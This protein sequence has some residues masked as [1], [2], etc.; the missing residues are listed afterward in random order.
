[1]TG[2]GDTMGKHTLP[3]LCGS[4]REKIKTSPLWS[5]RS[6]ETKQHL[7]GLI[8]PECGQASAWAYQEQ[9]FAISCNR[10]NT[11]GARVRTL[12]LF[13]ELLTDIEQ[14]F[15]PT[16][17]DPQRP[18]REYLHSRGLTARSLTGLR[19]EYWRDIRKSGSGGVMFHVG[20][21]AEK[22]VWNGRLFNPPAGEGKTHNKGATAGKFW[23]HPGKEYDPAEPIYATEGIVD[24][25]SLIEM[26]KQAIALLSAG[27]DPKGVDLGPMAASL[28]LAF[29]ADSA[30]A[31][32]LKKWKAAHP[33][34]RAIT[35]SGGD[36]NDLLRRHG[37]QAAH[38]FD[39][40]Q[41]EFEARAS[42]LLAP[43][44]MEY[45]SVFKGF[46]GY[47]PGLFVFDRCYHYAFTTKKSETGLSVYRV[48]NFTVEVDH[49]RLD[50]TLDDEPVYR[51]HLKVKPREGPAVQCSV[52]G[53]DLSNPGSIRSTLLTRARVMWEGEARPSTALATLIAEYKA[54]VVRQCHILG[55]D[56]KSD[57]MVF[58]D[59]LLDRNGRVIFPD[60]QGFYRSSSR[61]YIRPPKIPSLRPKSGGPSL[62]HIYRL[63]NTAWPDNGALC[64]AY[65]IASWFVNIIKPELGFFPFLSLHGDTQTGKTRLVRVL[66]ALQCVDEEGLPMTKLNTGKGEIRKLAQRSG[67]FKALLEGNKEEKLRFDLESLLT[68]YN[69]GN[70]LQVRATK[71][72]D[73]QTHDTEFLSTLVFVQNQEPFRGKAQMERVVSTA[74]F[75]TGNITSSTT[76]AFNELIRIPPR[77]LAHSYIDIMK[78]RRTIEDR[79]QAYYTSARGEVFGV[80]EDN[81]LAENHG[82]VLAFHRILMDLSGAENDLTPFV[83]ALARKKHERCAHRPATLADNF[84]EAV[85]E[86]S[87]ESR[88]KFCELKEGKLYLKL[89]LALKT[90]DGHGFKFMTNQI[91]EELKAHPAFIANRVIYRGYFGE[92]TSSVAR[93]WVFDA[94][95]VI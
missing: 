61:E 91:M 42:L 79:W 48:S 73:I 18:A 49:Y 8:C 65:T 15:A 7:T 21:L 23:Q 26:G 47:A 88:G 68:L 51:Y 67:L 32:G 50:S 54:P 93:L 3:S 33:R 92:M 40:K 71:T 53:S 81:R 86:L 35:P 70:A 38:V 25:L 63:I 39:E 19:Y 17:E 6:K 52:T 5:S 11:C 66:N 74:P 72:N 22:A 56:L 85:N 57:C 82:I 9:P 12:E 87:E 14:D 62:A 13:P 41:Q 36:W 59:F 60:K 43:S 27:Q 24:A 20:G 89:P 34:M 29:D 77:E 10:K 37:A 83:L 46:Y 76:Q 58:Q 75:R 44:A 2:K 78:Q 16:R 64:M 30:G 45:A 84:F 95:K 31:G 1:M 80:V 94:E 55:H 28:V 90:L 69:S 4:L